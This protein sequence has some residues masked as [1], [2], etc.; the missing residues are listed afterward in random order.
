MSTDEFSAPQLLMKYPPLAYLLNCLLHC[1][2]YLRE[3]PLVTTKEDLLLLLC[4]F[5]E[6]VS[7]FVVEKA[8]DIRRLGEKYFGDGYMRENVVRSGRGSFYSRVL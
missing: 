1:L 4:R 2:N 5:V 6:S 8:A 7:A 3:C